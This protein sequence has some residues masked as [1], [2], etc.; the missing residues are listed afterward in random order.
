MTE[1]RIPSLEALATILSNNGFNREHVGSTIRAVQ[2]YAA[3]LNLTPHSTASSGD[4]AGDSWWK[5]L[6]G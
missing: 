1:G 2:S 3:L 4:A 6:F 5:R